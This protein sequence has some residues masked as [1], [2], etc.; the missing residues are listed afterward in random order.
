MKEALKLVLA[1]APW[2]AFW[3]ISGPSMLRLK[4][5]ILVASVLVIVMG[6]TKLHRGSIL[7]AGYIFFA[8]TLISVVWLEN[9]WVI[10]HL[11]LLAPATLFLAVQLSILFGHPFTEMYAKEQT[12]EEYWNTPSFIKAVFISSSIW[13]TIFLINFLLNLVKLNYSD[14]PEWYFS[15][16]EYI[17]ILAGI[18]I[19][20]VRSNMAKKRRELTSTT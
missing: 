12:P 11:G 3:F 17:V 18:I 8:F 7:W 16:S 5:A 4:I 9:M 2:L 6:I 14:I 10:H 19:T 20:T 15:A 13:A 1:F